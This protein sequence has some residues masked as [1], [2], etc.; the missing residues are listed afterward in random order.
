M[1]ERPPRISKHTT[2]YHALEDKIRKRHATGYLAPKVQSHRQHQQQQQERD[3]QHDGTSPPRPH[4]AADP[5]D[6]LAARL[7]THPSQLPDVPP[8]LA[9]PSSDL[10]DAVHGHAALLY[11]G[12]AADE[13]NRQAAAPHALQSMNESALLTIGIVV[14]EWVKEAIGADG[15]FCLTATCENLAREEGVF[16]AKQTTCRADDRDGSNDENE[17]EETENAAADN[18]PY[19]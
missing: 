13:D 16:P 10:L 11:G 14:E 15:H 7:G 8:S 18:N 17:E 12:A 3:Q 5:R 1:S 19:T 9:L 2:I 4:R 6:A